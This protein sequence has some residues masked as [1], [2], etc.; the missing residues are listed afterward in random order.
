MAK[1][2]GK[3]AAIL[4]YFSLLGW[5]IALIVNSG[6]KTKLGSFHIRQALMLMLTGIVLGVIPIVNIVAVL[7]ILVFWIMGVISAF[8]GKEKLLPLIGQYGQDW[9]K[10]L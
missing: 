5:I 1:D 9:F 7:V 10:G 8:Q 2:D 3:L 4:A 6:N